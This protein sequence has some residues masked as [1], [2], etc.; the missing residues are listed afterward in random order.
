MLNDYV[1]GGSLVSRTRK[2]N[3]YIYRLKGFKAACCALPLSQYHKQQIY[4]AVDDTI[5]DIKEAQ[6]RDRIRTKQ[7]RGE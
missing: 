7:E 3:W 1:A 6:R 5:L 4:K 2:R